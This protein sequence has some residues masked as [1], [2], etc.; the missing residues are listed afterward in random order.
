M[1][2]YGS[3]V[4]GSGD[5]AFKLTRV[6]DGETCQEIHILGEDSTFRDED[7]ILEIWGR[8]RK[9]RNAF[10]L[11][12]VGDGH[13]FVLKIFSDTVQPVEPN[14]TIW[15]SK[16]VVDSALLKG[17][18]PTQGLWMPIKRQFKKVVELRNEIKKQ[19]G[20]AQRSR[21]EE[22]RKA[23]KKALRERKSELKELLADG[24]THEDGLFI[25]FL[26]GPNPRGGQR[27]N[28]V[29]L[30]LMTN[31]CMR[32]EIRIATE[33]KTEDKGEIAAI[34]D[35]EFAR[36]SATA[37]RCAVA[38]LAEKLVQRS[39]EPALNGYELKQ[40]SLDFCDAL[41][42]QILSDEVARRQ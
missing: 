38:K 13:E 41:E 26:A 33:S 34:I 17:I 16:L 18:D 20:I 5:M 15:A 31:S 8:V 10:L 42:E 1:L 14:K 25:T 12:E 9:N 27:H 23:A 24:N 32:E 4:E 30:D 36:R 29:V 35:K 6:I 11:I 28:L 7:K 19:E 2:E 37:Q 22:R 39:E 21:S 40:L 3:A